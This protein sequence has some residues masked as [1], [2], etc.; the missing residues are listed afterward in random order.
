VDR[1]KNGRKTTWYTALRT[2]LS[3]L[4][5]DTASASKLRSGHYDPRTN[6]WSGL[7]FFT[8]NRTWHAAVSM[9]GQ[10]V[11]VGGRSDAGGIEA[12]TSVTEA[13]TPSSNSW[14]TRAPM[15]AATQDVN[16]VQINGVVYVFSPISTYVYQALTDTL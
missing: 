4:T 11:I 2:Q 15:P 10:I 8:I 7:T 9:G 14:K 6:L 16:A 5:E 1:G 13:Y 3:Y 12:Q